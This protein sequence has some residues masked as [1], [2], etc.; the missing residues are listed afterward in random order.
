MESDHHGQADI[1]HLMDVATAGTQW[2]ASWLAWLLVW[3]CGMCALVA[4]LAV[5][6]LNPPQHACQLMRS[7]WASSISAG[8]AVH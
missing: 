7:P 2:R 3:L 8:G 5:L 1:A 6:A 4:A